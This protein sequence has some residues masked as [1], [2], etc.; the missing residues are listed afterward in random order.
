MRGSSPALWFNSMLSDEVCG[1]Y[2]LSGFVNLEII[3]FMAWLILKDLVAL[4]GGNN[5][6]I[7]S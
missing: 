7:S 4:G 2:G 5:S 3:F 6:F 1:S